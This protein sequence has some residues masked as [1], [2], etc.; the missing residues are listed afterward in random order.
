MFHLFPDGPNKVLDLGCGS[1]RVG[2]VL[3]DSGKAAEV[4]GVEIFEPAAAEARKH[5]KTVHTGDIEEMT[6]DYRGD[7]DMVV[8]GDVLEH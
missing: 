1:G 5:Y 4:T 2:K 6:L 8:C 3:L 7:F